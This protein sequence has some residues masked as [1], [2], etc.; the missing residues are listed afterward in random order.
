MDQMEIFLDIENA[1]RAYNWFHH[2]FPS[3]K[4]NKLCSPEDIMLRN[5]LERFLIAGGE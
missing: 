5:K 1:K 4:D 3:Y 2:A